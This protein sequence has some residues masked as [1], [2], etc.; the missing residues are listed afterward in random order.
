MCCR[1]V[2]DEFVTRVINEKYD[3]VLQQPHA[4]PMDFTARPMKE[5][6]FVG[7]EGILDEAALMQWIELG[8]EHARQAVGE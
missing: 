8:V 1:V 4:R 2:K 3:R 5:F 6:V 7:Q